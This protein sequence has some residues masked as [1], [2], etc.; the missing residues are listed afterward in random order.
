VFENIYNGIKYYNKN[1]ILPSKKK[2]FQNLNFIKESVLK[3]EIATVLKT[4]IK[5]KRE[6]H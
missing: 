3:K 6:I 5:D 4:P 1:A 2:V